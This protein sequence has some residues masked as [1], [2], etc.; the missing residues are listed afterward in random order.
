MAP[1]PK[2]S[3]AA[4]ADA[5]SKTPIIMPGAPAHRRNCSFLSQPLFS[6]RFCTSEAAQTCPAKRAKASGTPTT[7]NSDIAVIMYITNMSAELARISR[8]VAETFFITAAFPT[9]FYYII[10][11]IR[12]DSSFFGQFPIFDVRNNMNY[13]QNYPQNHE[14]RAGINQNGKRQNKF[15]EPGKKSGEI[16]QLIKYENDCE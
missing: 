14:E 3:C 8:I 9:L 4:S 5:V 12:S 10:S 15:A 1:N 11:Q 16:V 13:Q 7:A 6:K 2:S